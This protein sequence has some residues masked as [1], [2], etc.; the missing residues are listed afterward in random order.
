VRTCRRCS[1][2]CWRQDCVEVWCLWKA[3][4]C[5]TIRPSELLPI[6]ALSSLYSRQQIANRICAASACH[7]RQSVRINANHFSVVEQMDRLV[8]R[9]CFCDMQLSLIYRGE[10]VFGRNSITKIVAQWRSRLIRWNM[11]CP[12]WQFLSNVFVPIRLFA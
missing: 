4:D 1:N 3:V 2:R 6:I 11:L 8:C 10:R 9:L 7:S 5:P 12:F